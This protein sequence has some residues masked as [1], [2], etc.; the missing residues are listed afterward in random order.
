MIFS[1]KSVDLDGMQRFAQKLAPTLK[2]GD[3]IC[4]EGDLGAG[5]T[6]LAGFII[7]E[8]VPQKQNITSP[9]FNLVHTY[10]IPDF[11]IWH[12]D[13]YRLKHPDEIYSI[14][15]EDALEH[16]VSIIEWH[17]IIE[18]MLPSNSLVISIDFEDNRSSIKARYLKNV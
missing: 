15:I 12:F 13:L 6:T 5:K 11:S 18:D 16:G 4:L 3:V 9:T 1:S 7:N 17:K 10:K 2:R 14:G 8:L